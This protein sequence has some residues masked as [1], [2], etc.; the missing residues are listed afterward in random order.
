MKT[1]FK[2]KGLSFKYDEEVEVKI[3]EIETSFEGTIT[4]ITQQMKASMEMVKEY[5]KMANGDFDWDEDHDEPCMDN[6]REELH[7]ELEL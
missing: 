6:E 3:E 4:D 5:V 1:G 7:K 2:L